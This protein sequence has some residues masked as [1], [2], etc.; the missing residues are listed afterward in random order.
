MI[1]RIYFESMAHQPTTRHIFSL[2]SLPDWRRRFVDRTLVCLVFLAAAIQV[3]PVGLASSATDP[4]QLESTAADGLSLTRIVKVAGSW[5][6]LPTL[7]AWS[8]VARCIDGERFQ[9]CSAAYLSL[10]AISS[11]PSCCIGKLKV[12]SSAICRR[13]LVDLNVRLQI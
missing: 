3:L 12:G 13:T 11:R 6:T 4:T 9:H 1:H 8:V 5:T 2:G 7:S 10:A